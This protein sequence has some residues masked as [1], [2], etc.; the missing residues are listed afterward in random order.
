MNNV[1]SWH[2]VVATIILFGTTLGNIVFTY[3]KTTTQ[4]DAEIRELIRQIN[5]LEQTLKECNVYVLQDNVSNHA[6]RL[7]QLDARVNALNEIIV[8]G[9]AQLQTRQE[10]ILERLPK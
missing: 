7:D 6:A 4:S 5:D 10:M 2:L 8:K 1:K 9:L 3:T